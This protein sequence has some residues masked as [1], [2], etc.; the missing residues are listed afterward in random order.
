[1]AGFEHVSVFYPRGTQT[2][3]PEALHQLV[4]ALRS[5]GHDAALVPL[6][7][8]ESTPRVARYDVYDAPEIAHPRTGR[9]DAVVCPEVWV[10]RDAVIGRATR[11]CWW[12]SI[13]NS[14]VFA[15]LRR[16]ENAR[17]LGLP[18]PARQAPAPGFKERLLPLVW[19]RRLRAAHH[20]AQSSYAVDVVRRELGAEARLLS[21]YVRGPGSGAGR[22]EAPAAERWEARV[23][24]FNP[25]KGGDLVEEVRRLVGPRVT[26]LPIT[27]MTPEQAQAALMRS[28]VYLDLGHQPGKDRMP[29]EAALAG[30]VTLVAAIGA[31]AHESD[32]PLPSEHRIPAGPDIVPAAAR[33]LEAVLDDLPGH[34]ARQ[35]GFREHLSRE[36]ETFLDEVR[37]VFG[38]GPSARRP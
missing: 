31:G 12:L 4:D 11:F 13:D 37:A 23:V 21:D 24:A 7:G 26:W 36:R 25:G 18:A 14:P 16:R 9:A 1:M 22:A 34:W 33:A 28:A 15:S 10:P 35:S 38:P 17:L 8:T 30:A 2:G 20:L 19:R 5:L 29:R 27:G 32:F 3:G 6:P